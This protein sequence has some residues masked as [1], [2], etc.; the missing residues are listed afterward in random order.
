MRGIPLPP[1]TTKTSSVPLQELLCFAEKGTFPCI[2]SPFLCRMSRHITYVLQSHLANETWVL[3]VVRRKRHF[4]I[5]AIAILPLALLQRSKHSELLT[6]PVFLFKTS[7]PLKMQ[8][9]AC[10]LPWESGGAVSHA[11][12]LLCIFRQYK[13]MGSCVKMQ[14]KL[15]WPQWNIKQ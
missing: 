2:R 6:V 1:R 8:T 7:L 5:G 3:V 13:S 10:Y 15:H 9:P 11:S 14:A 4:Q 12:V